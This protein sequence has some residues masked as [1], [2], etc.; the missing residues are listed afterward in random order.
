V[1]LESPWALGRERERRGQQSGDE[2][3]RDVSHASNLTSAVVPV[4]H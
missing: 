2:R 4:V 3:R 1:N